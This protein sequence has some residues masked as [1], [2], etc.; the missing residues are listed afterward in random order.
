[1]IQIL[2]IS[3]HIY[4]MILQILED[5]TH[6]EYKIIEQLSSLNLAAA[7][8]LFYIQQLTTL[9]S[10]LFALLR[11]KRAYTLCDKI[12]SM[13]SRTPTILEEFCPST[14]I[15]INFSVPEGRTMILTSELSF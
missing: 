12:F 9:L 6:I 7:L 2:L 1:M 11:T 8:Q 4:V 14:I 3:N 15:R 10:K 5:H 13:A